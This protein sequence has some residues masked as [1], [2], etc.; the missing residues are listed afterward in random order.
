MKNKISHFLL[1]LFFSIILCFF[2]V[3]NCLAE[4]VQINRSII[5]Y[6]TDNFIFRFVFQGGYY[7][8]GVI[9][10]IT[11]I[12]LINKKF[13][14][15]ILSILLAFLGLALMIFAYEAYL[16]FQFIPTA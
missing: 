4:E 15:V 13:R 10:I 8:L 11:I 14:E 1:K 7:S 12:S 3:F 2:P 16:D 6:F 9:T 5:S